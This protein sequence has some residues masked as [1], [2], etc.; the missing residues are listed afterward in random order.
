MVQ[1]IKVSFC[2]SHRFCGNAN[3]MQVTHVL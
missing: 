3:A 2:M 1:D